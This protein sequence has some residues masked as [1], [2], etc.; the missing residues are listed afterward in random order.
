EDVVAHDVS[1]C[2]RE[3]PDLFSHRRDGRA[4][5]RLAGVV[6]RRA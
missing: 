4:A 2:T 5:G 6:R 3:S 1:R